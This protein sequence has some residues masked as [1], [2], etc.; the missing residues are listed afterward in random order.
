M[1]FQ[2]A[3]FYHLARLSMTRSF[4]IDEP[5]LY[6]GK[7]RV[8]DVDGFCGTVEYVGPV[9]SAKNESEIYVGIAWDDPKRG[10]HDGSVIC[11]KTKQLVRHFSCKGGSFLRLSKVDT[12]VPLNMPVVQSK[13]VQPDAPLVAPN[14]VLPHS[15]RTSSGREKAIEFHGEIKVRHHQ[16]IE[17]LSR[18][19]LRN[20]GISSVEQNLCGLEHIV[21]LDLGGNLLCDWNVLSD[22]LLAFPNL[23]SL[24][25][26]ANRLGDLNQTPF[27]RN[28]TLSLL[29]VHSCGIRSFSTIQKLNEAFPSIQQFCV[30]G[31]DLSDLT[32]TKAVVG[33]RS[34]IHLDVSSCHL[35][36]WQDHINKLSSFPALETLLINNNAI[37]SIPKIDNGMFRHLRNLNVTGLS[38]HDWNDVQRMSSLPSLRSLSLRNT[39][40]TALIGAS[41]A[42]FIIIARLP[43]LEMVNSSPISVKERA[44]AEKRYVGHVAQ[45]LLMMDK[46]EALRLEFLATNHP[47][48]AC[49]AE[50]FQLEMKS[51]GCDFSCERGSSYNVN[52][53]I[54][55]ISAESCQ[56]EPI[57]KR[58]PSSLTVGRLK[59][60]CVRVFGLDFD[61]QV[62]H[63]RSEVRS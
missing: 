16:Q 35:T 13:Y 58:L 59:A 21:D 54:T 46:T 44:E 5:H 37:D 8:R 61:L 7:T 15:A 41:E 1:V 63:Y 30:A 11:R 34:L 19:A 2:K 50:K 10:K 45:E 4:E 51:Q 24:S 39:P 56:M 22:I 48:F 62:L 60:L 18:M 29:N 27:F 42:R 49:L 20:M 36:S 33:F 9:A 53:T 23:A 31:N 32:T 57:R 14:N 47:Q 38:I 25:L 26:A 40:L 3:P 6:T 12:G 55:S 43:N 52:V 17:V 28:A